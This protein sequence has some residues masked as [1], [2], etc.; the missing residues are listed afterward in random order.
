MK[1][2]LLIMLQYSPSENG[3]PR[4][5]NEK[6]NGYEKFAINLS[7]IKIIQYAYE[8]SKIRMFRS[9]ILFNKG[10]PYKSLIVQGDPEELVKDINNIIKN[11]M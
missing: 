11:K 9:Q 4:T 7:D 2:D 5:E 10:F 8:N 3:F 6:I 1:K